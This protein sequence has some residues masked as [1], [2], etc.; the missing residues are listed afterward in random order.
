MDSYKHVLEVVN[1]RLYNI[2]LVIFSSFV[3][4]MNSFIDR[5]LFRLLLMIKSY[6][7][8]PLLP[9]YLGQLRASEHSEWLRY[10][11]WSMS[12]C[13]CVCTQRTSNANSPKTVKLQTSNLT[14]M[15]LFYY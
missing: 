12:V 7:Q 14:R 4:S 15:F 3:S 9:V 5:L 11:F 1:G 10:C 2:G 8:L 6:Q 13:L